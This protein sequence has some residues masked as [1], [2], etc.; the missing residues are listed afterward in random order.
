MAELT[1]IE[2]R[3]YKELIRQFRGEGYSLRVAKENAMR[4]V[5][6]EATDQDNAEEESQE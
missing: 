3:R 5:A 6:E 2:Q 4:V 1:D